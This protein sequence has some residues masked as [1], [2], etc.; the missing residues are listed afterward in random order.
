MKQPSPQVQRCFYNELLPPDWEP[1][2]TCCVCDSLVIRQC[3]QALKISIP[4]LP[5]SGAESKCYNSC[6]CICFLWGQRE[7]KETTKQSK[8]QLFL[9]L[10]KDYRSRCTLFV[11]SGCLIRLL[12]FY[13][14]N[15]WEAYHYCHMYGV[16]AVLALH[17]RITLKHTPDG[18][19]GLNISFPLQQHVSSH[20]W[21]PTKWT[22]TAIWCAWGLCWTDGFILN[23]LNTMEPKGSSRT[24]LMF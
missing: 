24:Y 2:E 11:S 3:L 16:S 14:N 19:L 7:A 20:I 17:C 15:L 6:V 5:F 10:C 18:C 13:I 12:S 9:H 4:Y 1:G 23:L 22:V 21:G 8:S